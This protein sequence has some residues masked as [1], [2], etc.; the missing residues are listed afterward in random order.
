MSIFHDWTPREMSA[1][2]RATAKLR[3]QQPRD[4][5]VKPNLMGCRYV[6]T[7]GFYQI[8]VY[9]NK[10][11]FYCGTMKEWDEDKALQLQR[12]KVAEIEYSRKERK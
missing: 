10:E 1:L 9:H 7:R 4:V 8:D 5:F 12:E 6:P 11:R 3:A 2:S